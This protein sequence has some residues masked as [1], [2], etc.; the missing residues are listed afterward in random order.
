MGQKPNKTYTFTQN[1][2]LKNPDHAFYLVDEPKI[3]QALQSIT[4]TIGDIADCVTG[5]YSGN[6]KIFLKVK[7]KHIRNG[8]KYEVVDEEQIRQN[9]KHIR[10][11]VNS[12]NSKKVI[13][14]K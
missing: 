5:F 12:N 6:D 7:S 13:K 10:E 2:I 4:L 9:L 14:T 3:L 8:K 1:S 11:E